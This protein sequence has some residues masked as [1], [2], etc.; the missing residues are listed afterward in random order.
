MPRKHIQSAKTNNCSWPTMLQMT[1]DR[2]TTFLWQ[3]SSQGL[4]DGAPAWGT[5]WG[6][7]SC[8]NSR[9]ISNWLI[10]KQLMIVHIGVT[11]MYTTHSL[12][13]SGLNLPYNH[14]SDVHIPQWDMYSRTYQ[15][16]IFQKPACLTKQETS[17]V[18][19]LNCLCDVCLSV[20]LTQKD[21]LS[22]R[23]AKDDMTLISAPL[24][25]QLFNTKPY[26]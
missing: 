16:Q 20:C 2:F 8:I 15:R 5:L 17:R 21:G 13:K 18:T 19:G 23:K 24:T 25:L 1:D 14:Q 12:Q 3:A 4:N 9:Y 6:N 22:W 7:E 11:Q 10:R 26:S